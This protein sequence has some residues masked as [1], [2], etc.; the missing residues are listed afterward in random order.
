M[1][2]DTAYREQHA[3]LSPAASVKMWSCLN[4]P[5]LAYL[6]LK[7]RDVPGTPGLTGGLITSPLT[8]FHSP[9]GSEF[10]LNPNE[11]CIS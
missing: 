1:L 10:T 9:P 3:S 2:Q 8:D 6:T 7:G 5:T 4:A 11:T